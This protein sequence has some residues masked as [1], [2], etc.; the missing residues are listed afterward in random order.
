[1]PNDLPSGNRSLKSYFGTIVSGADFWPRP[2]I[3]EPLVSSMLRGQSHTM[4]GLRR[5][6]KSSIMAEVK[7]R[8]EAQGVIVSQINAESGKGLQDV[9]GEL[10][11][12]LPAPDLKA[13][14]LK[15]IEQ[16]QTIAKPVAGLV[17]NWL[18]AA[19]AN[20]NAPDRD[21]LDYWPAISPMLLS[22]LKAEKRHIALL[23]DELPFLIE[24]TLSGG[25]GGDAKQGLATAKQILVT[26]R[27]WRNLKHVSMLVAGSIGM[28]GLAFRHGLDPGA[29]SDMLVVEVP[30]L[31]RES[32]AVQMLRALVAGANPPLPGWTEE[33]TKTLLDE[34]PDHFPGFIQLGFQ[35]VAMS[36]SLAPDDI[37][38]CLRER[39][40]PQLHHQFFS[41]FDNR[42]RREDT[43]T[44]KHLTA[45]I[46]LVVDSSAKDGL[47]LDAFYEEMAR[48]GC[49]IPEEIASILRED[50][51]L[52]FDRDTRTFHP[53]CA[54]V[55]A[56]RNSTP[57]AR[58]R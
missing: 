20:T 53:A 42:L 6:G 2:D 23:V 29:F 48:R 35:A 24:N 25:K 40:E 50:G 28:R 33:A 22:A 1:M 36:D 56:W 5:T 31:K 45:A 15:H 55:V 37:R 51:F 47:P 16:V 38:H 18:G 21:L 11:R 46:D 12:N 19:P 57:R 44:R 32:E 43:A 39:L 14:L 3:V 17:K 52:A 26:L 13:N 41:Q 49:E 4:F 58:R 27:E 9:F 8:L 34:L 30:P 10:L 54:M 7:A